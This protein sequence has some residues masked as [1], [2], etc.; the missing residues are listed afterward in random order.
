MLA[1]SALPRA[2]WRQVQRSN[3]LE[4]L[5]KE[6]QRRCRVV[7]IFPNEAAVIRLAGLG[8]LPRKSSRLLWVS[9][10]GDVH[11]GTS[12]IAAALPRLDRECHFEPGLDDPACRR[13]RELEAAA[14]HKGLPN[15]PDVD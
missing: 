11:H 14:L 9:A 10:T 1:F 4:R 7:G 13:G 6:L 3:P 2:H 12:V 5:N 8:R 15:S